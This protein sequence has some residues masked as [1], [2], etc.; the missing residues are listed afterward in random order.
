[1]RSCLMYCIGY[2]LLEPKDQITYSVRTRSNERSLL[3]CW[4][5]FDC[6]NDKVRPDSMAFTWFT[7]HQPPCQGCNW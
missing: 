4:L 6:L 3:A 7:S 2:R 1:M 5:L